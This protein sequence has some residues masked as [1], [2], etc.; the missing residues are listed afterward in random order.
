MATPP[1][2]TQI[3]IYNQIL[4][5]VGAPINAQNIAIMNGLQVAEGA[6]NNNIGNTTWNMG[7]GTGTVINSDGVMRYNSDAIGVSAM[8]KTLNQPYMA[9]VV[10]A[11]K[12]SDPSKWNIQ[13]MQDAMTHYSG[14]SKE[15]NRMLSVASNNT[16]S[17]SANNALSVAA[18]Q[19]KSTTPSSKNDSDPATLVGAGPAGKLNT[20]MLSNPQT[21]S[22]AGNDN[23]NHPM[24]IEDGLYET[25]WFKELT[26]KG[27]LVVGNKTN[28]SKKPISFNIITSPNSLEYLPAIKG[29]DPSANNK[30]TLILNCSLSEMSV[31]MK[32]V[33]QRTPTR[34][35]MHITLW[36][37][38]PDVISGSGVTGAWMNFFGLNEM[39]STQQSAFP[40]DLKT[41]IAQ[42]YS[43]DL[44]AQGLSK[45]KPGQ[46]GIN[47]SNTTAYSGT[48]S[49]LANAIA[50]VDQSIVGSNS[51]VPKKPATPAPVVFDDTFLSNQAQQLL[52]SAAQ[53]AFAELIALFKYNAI[54]RFKT[55]NYTGNISGRDQEGTAIWSANTGTGDGGTPGNIYAA[56]ARNNDVMYRGYVVMNTPSGKYLGY[57]K[58]LSFTEDAD[59][60]YMWGFDFVFQV[61]KT[62][63]SYHKPVTVASQNAASA[64]QAAVNGSE[65]QEYEN[66]GLPVPPG[67]HH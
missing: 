8:T 28:P 66:A 26:D 21:P 53:D 63:K 40:G 39:M 18:L 47:Q 19:A 42:N 25:P 45:G 10:D 15:L 31:S 5:G 54:T 34:T 20:V 14:D 64:A 56:G 4:T 38:E 48:G 13:G 17:Q 24:I 51:S 32:H 49:G 30:A 67:V 23:I 3:G 6:P 52:R 2:P 62:L 60:P 57:F 65:A 33:F 46:P 7:S 9:P 43:G 1:T 37:T 61:Q 58:N 55:G 22:D 50:K 41:Y 12:E 36:G 44:S 27:G 11:L 59:K 29:Q 16:G 35:G